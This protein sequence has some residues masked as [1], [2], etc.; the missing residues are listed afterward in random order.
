M[1]ALSLPPP[2]SLYEA[3]RECLSETNG[4]AYLVKRFYGRGPQLAKA[5]SCSASSYSICPFNVT[6]Y[7]TANVG[8]QDGLIINTLEKLHT[9]I[10]TYIHTYTHTHIFYIFYIV[11]SICKYNT[12]AHT[13]THTN[14]HTHTYIYINIYIYI[15]VCVCVSFVTFSLQ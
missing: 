5:F 8:R 2:P 12:R 4:P 11:L 7:P 3:S 14:T 6:K 10:H 15:C 9:Y 1:P 13:R